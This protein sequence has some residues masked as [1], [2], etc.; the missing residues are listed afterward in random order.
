MAP[1]DGAFYVGYE[2]MSASEECPG[3]EGE[4]A[5]SVGGQSPS[6]NGARAIAGDA[7]PRAR[8]TR[9]RQVS[10]SA[11]MARCFSITALI[12]AAFTQTG[13]LV[14][15]FGTGHLRAGSGVAVDAQS[16]VVFVADASRIRSR[17]SSPKN[18][19]A[20]AI[21]DVSAQDL[22]PRIGRTAGADRSRAVR[23]RVLRVRVRHQRLRNRTGRAC[24]ERWGRAR[25]RP[26]S[27]IA[28]SACA[29]TGLA[30]GERLLL[31]GARVATQ[32]AGGRRAVA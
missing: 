7:D 14:E 8:S 13:Q 28:K 29:C 20:P 4:T 18:R 25:C 22:T 17:C 15:R 24:T 1:G 21:D 6:S 32:L 26:A 16:G 3:E 2:R 19:R 23:R 10:L 31:P 27:A 9:T 11:A 30:A 5:G 12:V